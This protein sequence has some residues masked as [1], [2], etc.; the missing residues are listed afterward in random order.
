M[1]RRG[2]VEGDKEWKS[3]SGDGRSVNLSS[4]PCQAVALCCQNLVII[5]DFSL[6]PSSSMDKTPVSSRGIV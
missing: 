4:P 2:A 6:K 1:R 3:D 5:E